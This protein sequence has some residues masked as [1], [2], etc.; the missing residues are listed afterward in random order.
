MKDFQRLAIV[1]VT[2]AFISNKSWDAWRIYFE[3]K[4]YITIAPPW[5]YKDASA[6]DLRKR[7][8][9]VFLAS[10]NLNQLIDHYASIIKLLPEKP[11]L[12]G[13]SVGGLV[14][15][16]LI[17][18]ELAA[19]GV[20]IHSLPPLGV[21]PFEISF[22]KSWW[23][24]LHPFTSRKETY[25]MSFQTWQYFFTNGMGPDEQKRAYNNFL[26]PES[27]L[28]I[29][30]CLFANVAVDFKKPHVPLLILAGSTDNAIPASLNWRN[31]KKY[32]DISSVTNFKMLE[33]R[34]HFVLCQATW[35]EDARY[36]LTWLEESGRYP[37][38]LTCCE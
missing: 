13:H 11:I 6:E 27:K 30:D 20:V 25:L 29:R 22:W 7:Q 21:I 1:F 10:V 17:N 33:G 19:A 14:T 4:G 38:E 16:V 18:R 35:H 34:N 2:G 24:S 9:D 3:T 28:I 8:P 15:Q 31:Y 36:V 12:I 32:Q 26:V 37:T 23:K 5:P